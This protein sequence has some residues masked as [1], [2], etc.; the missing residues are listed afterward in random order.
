M[1][2]NVPL[3]AVRRSLNEAVIMNMSCGADKQPNI[4]DS[5]IDNGAPGHMCNHSN[6]QNEGL[7]TPILVISEP[8]AIILY[9]G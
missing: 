2:Q 3:T 6:I 9:C 7:R 4:V 5:P 1:I 8:P